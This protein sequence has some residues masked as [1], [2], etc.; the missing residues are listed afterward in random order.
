MTQI[1][2][3]NWAAHSNDGQPSLILFVFTV[4]TRLLL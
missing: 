1:L 2:Y 3:K 4:I